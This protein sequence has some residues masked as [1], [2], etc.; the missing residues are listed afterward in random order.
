MLAQ[1]RIY[2][3]VSETAF[4]IVGPQQIQHFPACCNPSGPTLIAGADDNSQRF[5]GRYRTN[6]YH[7]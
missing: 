1:K 6:V 3:A 4:P 7:R 5:G 2:P